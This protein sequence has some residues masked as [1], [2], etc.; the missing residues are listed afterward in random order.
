MRRQQLF[1]DRLDFACNAVMF[2]EQ[3]HELIVVHLK[4]LFL[5]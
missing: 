1:A 4:L 2:F 5:E 3:E